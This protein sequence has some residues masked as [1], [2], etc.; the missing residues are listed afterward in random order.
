MIYNSQLLC[1]TN[2]DLTYSQKYILGQT[3][4]SPSRAQGVYK[5]NQANFQISRRD[6]KK[7]PGHVSLASATYVM[8]Q[9]YYYLMEHV[10]MSSKQ[11]SS[12]C[13]STDYNISC[14]T[15]IALFNVQ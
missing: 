4:A 1:F 6:F 15:N 14:I 10:M 13:Y 8:Y 12:L 9:I 5:F 11:R 2:G 3:L 7:N